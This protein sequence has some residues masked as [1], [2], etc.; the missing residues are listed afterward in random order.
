MR[1]PRG[2]ALCC[3]SI[4]QRM[5]WTP[6]PRWQA[7]GGAVVALAVSAA[8]DRGPL[9]APFPCVLSGPAWHFALM[10]ADDP[11]PAPRQLCAWL[12]EQAHVPA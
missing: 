8:F 9:I 3:R 11:R 1:E 12:C 5:S 6:M 4:I 10:R 2:S 7:R